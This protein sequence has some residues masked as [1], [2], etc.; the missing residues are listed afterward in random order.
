MRAVKD[1][2]PA[3]YGE[4]KKIRRASLD[5]RNR[6]SADATPLEKGTSKHGWNII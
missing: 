5:G 1:S 3:P 6:I 2:L 4:S